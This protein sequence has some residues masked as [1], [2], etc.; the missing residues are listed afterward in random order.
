MIALSLLFGL[1][2]YILLIWFAVRAVGWLANI[3][4]FTTVTKR[5]L[6]VLCAAFFV[7]LP[8]WDIIPSRMYFQHLCEQ[9]AGVKVRRTVEVDQSYFT[10]DGK[11]DYKKLLEN[12]T[13]T[14]ERDPGFS[15]WA[16]IVKVKGKI[17]EKQTGEFLGTATDFVYYGGW[18]GSRIDA[19]SSVTCPNHPNHG[20]HSVIWQEIF[21][22]KQPSLPGG[23]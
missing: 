20:V 22:L 14:S 17:L 21:K 2:L 23:K 13:Q 6:Q 19:M 4:A 16:H 3:L 15:S 12:Y 5:V 18:L 8:T 11:P 9:E 7:L 1:M 10:A